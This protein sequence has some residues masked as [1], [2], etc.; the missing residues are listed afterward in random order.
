M[1][2]ITSIISIVYTPL[3]LACC[4]ARNGDI[5]MVLATWEEVQDTVAI[6]SV[7]QVTSIDA[8]S[9]KVLKTLT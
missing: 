4:S 2:Y 7:L 6:K 8:F 9:V 3:I 1:E 5:L